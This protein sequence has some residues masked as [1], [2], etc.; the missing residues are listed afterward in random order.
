[1]ASYL[2]YLFPVGDYP[3]QAVPGLLSEEEMLKNQRAAQTAGLL[4]M[5]LGIIAGSAPSRMPQGILQPIATGIMAGQQAYQG[6]LEDQQKMLAARAKA[7]EPKYEK[8]KSASGADILLQS[9]RRGGLSKVEIPGMNTDEKPIEFSQ[10]T[11]AWM[12]QNFGTAVYENLNPAQKQQ[13]LSRELQ[14]KREL[15]SLQGGI[16]PNA[17]PV[18][19]EG[20]NAVDKDLLGL[21]RSRLLLQRSAS[22]FSPEYLTL[23][24]QTQM[25]V[26]A[27][28]ERLNIPLN[29]ADKTKL[30]DY[31]Q[32]RQTSMN[33]LNQYIND[34]TGAAVGTGDE[35]K[36]LRAGIPDP[37][38]DS[39]TE[40][41]AKLQNTIALGKQ[42]EAR[43]GYVKRNGL[44]L[45]DVSVDQIPAKMRAREAEIIQKFNFDPT[46]PA[47]K[48]AIRTKLSEEFGLLE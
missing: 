37:Q 21:G 12:N 33:S 34:L 11:R 5:G 39:P 9:D 31:T 28:K 8:I 47:D 46:K 16:N 27:G 48:A 6:T 20:T 41:Q 29:E 13:A 1:M 24:F 43:L 10:P 19:K 7:L 40:F 26:A 45:T 42:F 38:K 25:N 14:T 17:L 2:D 32:F 18:G 36:R 22:Q 23:P 15:S 30:A 44:K 3:Q 35:E 4:N